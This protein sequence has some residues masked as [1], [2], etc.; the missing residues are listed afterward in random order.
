MHGLDHLIVDLTLILVAAGIVTVLFKKLRQP[1]VLGYIV[2]GILISPNFKYLPTPVSI[3]DINVWA[4]IGI[5]FLMFALGLEFSFHKIAKVGGSAVITAGT[6]MSAMIL[7]GFAVGSAMGW[8]VMNCVFLGGMMSMSSTMIILKSYDELNLKSERFAQVVLGALV[9]EDIAGIFMMIVL[10]TVSV[11]SSFSGVELAKE[12]TVLLLALVVI[13]CVGIYIV[14]T[15]LNKIKDLINKE[16]LLIISLGFCMLMVIISTAIGFSE[17]LGAFLAGSILAGTSFA[18][19]IEELV[20]PIKDLFGAIF[21]VSVGM[22]I[23]P[24][25]L[26]EYIVPIVIVT[27]VTVLGQMIFSMIGAFLSGQT[28]ND[29]VRVGF[30]MVQV[31]EFSFI[32]AALGSSLGVMD[33]YLYQIIVF[34]SVFTIFFTPV[35]IKKGAAAADKINSVMPAKWMAVLNSYTE[36]KGKNSIIDSD[37]KTY[38]KLYL[39]KNI[40]CIALIFVIYMMGV[41]YVLPNILKYVNDGPTVRSITAIAVIAAMSPFINIICRKKSVVYNKLWMKNSINKVPLIITRALSVFISA[42]AVMGV[43]RGV[44][45]ELPLWV[46]FIFAMIL[47]FFFAK[48]DFVKGKTLNL[49]VRFTANFNDKILKM[50][51]R[52]RLSSTGHHH[53]LEEI[54]AVDFQAKSRDSLR[55]V[56]D[57]DAARAFGIT[58]VQIQRAGGEYVNVIKAGT[59]IQEGDIITAV[60]SDYRIKAYLMMLEQNDYEIIKS[61]GVETLAEHI[62]TQIFDG[63]EPENRLVCVEIPVTRKMSFYKKPIR[64]NRFREKYKGSIIGVERNHLPILNPS[65]SFILSEGDTIWAV[66]T[67]IMVDEIMRLKLITEEHVGV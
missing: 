61:T 59:R 37:W 40:V 42:I 60:G 13:L 48:S 35:F 46:E 45:I 16:I 23:N 9:I 50:K 38:L 29:S 63:V 26:I 21:F 53:I 6:V 2:V 67:Q 51:R 24:P 39:M 43:I 20:Q 7:I 15:L 18:E 66:G 3:S 22:M 14:P 41:N 17:A 10:T 28:V 49:E 55:T 54:Y 5:V 11:S 65:P 56:N 57:F 52:E 27:A 47:V 32:L 62:Y 12:L 36:E 25:L 19:R 31:G 44:V 58:I 4:T 8:S 33:D 64:D 30:S 34:V 1:V